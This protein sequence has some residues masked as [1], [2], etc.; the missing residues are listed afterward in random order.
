MSHTRLSA[1]WRGVVLLALLATSGCAGGWRN[2]APPEGPAG[3][4]VTAT[5]QGGAQASPASGGTAMTADGVRFVYRGAGN[6]VA[7]GG[8]FN[9]WS[10]DAD[11]MAKQ[12]DGT[13]VL[14][15]K[16]EPGRY[17]YKFV[18]DGTWKPDD[19]AKESVDDGFGGKNSIIIVGSGAAS[20]TPATSAAAPAAAPA[21]TGAAGGGTAVTR[22]GVR[23]V[24]RGAANSVFLGG[25]FNG[26]ST[27]AEPMVKQADGT[28]VLVKQLEPGRYAYKFVVDGTWKP[29][30]VAKE[31]VDD[32]YGGKNSIIVVGEAAGGTAPT[33]PA[34]TTPAPAA[35]T[36]GAVTGKA[37]AP[38]ITPDGVK[39]T[40]AGAADRVNLAGDFNSWST[41]TDPMVRQAD[42]TWV[43]EKKLEPGT[44][45]YKFLVDGKTWKQDAANPEAKDDGFG[46]KNSVVT[47]P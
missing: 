28:W 11:P 4:Q 23:F 45:A 46:G 5:Q 1:L 6:S 21:T 39:F 43:I 20:S 32:G 3:A 15:K 40:Y 26:W 8:E 24:Y 14:V 33:A 36:A 10:T 31:S 34:S 12:A 13:W 38:Q 37:A 30:D 35:T 9:G 19:A 41:T 25:E 29:D 17:A 2:G 16:L 18:V 42:G 47:I 44:Y 22:D 27:T 7:L